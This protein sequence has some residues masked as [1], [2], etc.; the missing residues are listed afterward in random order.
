MEELKND[1]TTLKDNHDVLA[2]KVDILSAPKKVPARKVPG[3]QQS[4]SER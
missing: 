4:D 2:A 3:K 1:N